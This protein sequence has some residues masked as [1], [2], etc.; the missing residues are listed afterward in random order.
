MAQTAAG[1]NLNDIINQALNNTST[2]Q[3]AN[4]QLQS[5][6]SNSNANQATT[7][8]SQLPSNLVLSPNEIADYRNFAAAIPTASE[9]A[10]IN[11]YPTN[12]SNTFSPT[13]QDMT[14]TSN[15]SNLTNLF[16]NL[17]NQAQTALNN[18]TNTEDTSAGNAFL[19]T[20]QSPN[21]SNFAVS[22][23]LAGNTPQNQILN[24]YQQSYNNQSATL[25]ANYNSFMQNA[26]AA[27]TS[28]QNA[29][30]QL[31]NPQ[32]AQAF[33]MGATS[34]Y[35]QNVLNQMSPYLPSG[36]YQTLVDDLNN[37]YTQS[38]SFATSMNNL[39]QNYLG[40]NVNIIDDIQNLQPQVISQYY[41][42]PTSYEG[43]LGQ[44]LNTY[45]PQGY[46]DVVM[47]LP[48][49]S[50]ALGI[51]NGTANVMNGVSYILSNLGTPPA[52]VQTLPTST[53]LITDPTTPTDANAINA[54]TNTLVNQLNSAQAASPS[55]DSS[56]MVYTGPTTGYQPAVV[57]PT[58]PVIPTVLQPQT[59]AAPA[60]PSSA[61]IQQMQTSPVTQ[62]MPSMSYGFSGFGF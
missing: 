62:Q 50:Q 27:Q 51:T 28:M 40:M 13:F 26:S 43:T 34:T 16:S 47:N 57:V 12:L 20:W 22:N 58:A 41:S 52:T 53:S 6:F 21:A 18:Y 31:N 49:Q 8:S 36:S 10:S 23:S 59:V 4:S 19:N 39:F 2:V 33:V 11:S 45:N 1:S 42:N 37:N 44:T 9:A 38:E 61:P 60:A 7:G 25:Q 14:N 35:L 30:T 32:T 5:L 17:S 29:I 3:N 56:S 48:P 55:S 24:Q 54:M 15:Y 46:N